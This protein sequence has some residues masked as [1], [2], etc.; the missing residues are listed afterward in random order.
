M[1]KL[2]IVIISLFLIVNSVSGKDV[3]DF[4]LDLYRN[5]D[6]YRSISEF[7][8]FLFY[9]PGSKKKN[10]AYL[11][12]I[13]SYYY[14][15]QY[16]QAV[17]E[18]KKNKDKVL[19][20]LY[21]DQFDLLLA[22][23]YLYLE[24]DSIAYKIFNDLEEKSDHPEIKEQANYGLIWARIFKQD[25]QSAYELINKFQKNDPKSK[26]KNEAVLLKN[27]IKKGINF[28]PL[29]PT[30]AGIMSAIFPG[31][32]QVYCKRTGDG[33]VALTFISLLSYGTY[34]YYNNGP[35]GMFYGFAV[36]DAIFYLGNIYTAYGSAS[37]YNRNFHDQLKSDMINTYSY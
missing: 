16:D 20:K 8:R 23:S 9:Y 14:A 29:S 17:S 24:K 31:L 21:K 10:D 34:Y 4:A 30:L 28:S 22:K 15:G 7:N 35:D 37:K 13:K 33:I 1:K 27:D 11:Y 32:G 6:Y 18:I 12:I 26:L 2:L 36:L 3:F 19:K 5:N 25:W